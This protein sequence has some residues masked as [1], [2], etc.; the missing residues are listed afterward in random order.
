[1]STKVAIFFNLSYP[2]T[3]FSNF[4]LS[5]SSRHIFTQTPTSPYLYNTYLLHALSKFPTLSV[6]TIIK[7]FNELLNKGH[8]TRLNDELL[9]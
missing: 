7:S 1:M 3:N 2:L 9:F 4:F 6:L 5:L 8:D